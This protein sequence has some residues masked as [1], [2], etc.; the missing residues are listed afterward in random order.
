M[1][2]VKARVELTEEKIGDGNVRYEPLDAD[3]VVDRGGKFSVDTSRRD[4]HGNPV[5]EYEGE[6][7]VID[8]VKNKIQNEK[9]VEVLEEEVID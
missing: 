3:K 9:A 2:R 5:V 7:S 6:D 8:E 4:A 1:K